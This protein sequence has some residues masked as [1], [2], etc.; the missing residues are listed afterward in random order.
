L[1]LQ[2]TFNFVVPFI[3]ASDFRYNTVSVSSALNSDGWIS[4]WLLNPLTYP[5]QTPT[6]QQIVMMLSGGA[7]FTYRLPISPP[8]TQSPTDTPGP[9][10]NMECG[11]V[12]D[13]DASV[14]S[15]HSVS[16]PTPHTNVGF[17]YD[18]YRFIGVVES[19]N[20]NGPDAVSPIDSSG[21][22]RNLRE[23]LAP[24]NP[25]RRPY[26]LL[27]LSPVPSFC[28]TNL[29]AVM[30]AKNT[31]YNKLMFLTTGDSFL[32][33]CCPFTYIKCDL[34]FTVVPPLNFQND[35]IVRWF[36]PGATID[37]SQSI[38][39]MTA[40]SSQLA[41][42]GATHASAIFS[43]NPTFCARGSTKVSAVIPFCLP[44]SLLP[45]Y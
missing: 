38:V 44:T 43:Y 4:V 24:T 34:E 41:D 27:A 7:D 25:T 11:I 26:S 30:L 39:G 40:T 18:R 13:K 2:S 31:T 20:R 5:P 42:D 35:Y 15:G 14:I 36:P 10:D 23:V 1:G 33:R 22:V 6:T 3:S 12:D 37:T 17:F 32:Y 9:H 8:V 28:G 45:L 19:T 16:L 29:S 21:K